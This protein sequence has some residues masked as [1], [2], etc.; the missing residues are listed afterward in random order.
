MRFFDRDTVLL[1]SL[2]QVINQLDH[3]KGT[4]LSQD[5]PYCTDMLLFGNV[6]GRVLEWFHIW[7]WGGAKASPGEVSSFQIE[8]SSQETYLRCKILYK[9]AEKEGA[10]SAL[11]HAPTDK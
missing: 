8:P 1:V 11:F 2:L 9:D 5:T 4:G 6:R 10:P 7:L 3:C